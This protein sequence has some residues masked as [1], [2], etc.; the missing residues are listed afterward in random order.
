MPVASVH[1]EEYSKLGEWVALA[2]KA[3]EAP[4]EEQEE[5][6]TSSEFN[7]EFDGQFIDVTALNEGER[8]ETHGHHNSQ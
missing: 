2:E 3:W 4:Q 8:A 1:S 5:E 6:E 7:E